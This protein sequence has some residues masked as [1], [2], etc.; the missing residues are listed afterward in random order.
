M[1]VLISSWQ[2]SYSG[3]YPS[4]QRGLTVNQLAYAFEGSNP[5]PPTF[6]SLTISEKKLSAGN[7]LCNMP[8]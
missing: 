2:H 6:Y 5:P 3:G 4:G 7:I 1:V 8:S